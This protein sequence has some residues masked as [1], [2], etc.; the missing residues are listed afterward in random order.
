MS[1]AFSPS[2]LHKPMA[3]SYKGSTRDFDSY[4]DGSTPSPAAKKIKKQ[5]NKTIDKRK[6]I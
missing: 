5:M 3:G 2:F 1:H 6:K 4:R